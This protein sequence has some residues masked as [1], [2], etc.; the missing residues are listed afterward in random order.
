MSMFYM[1]HTLEILRAAYPYLN[2]RS[3]DT[4]ELFIKAGDFFECL[5]KRKNKSFV[6][7]FSFQ[8]EDNSEDSDRIDV[9]GLLKSVREVCYEEEVKLIDSLINLFNIME[10][11]DTYKNLFSMMS[12]MDELGGLSSMFGQ[13]GSANPEDMLGILSSMLPE[14]DKD[15]IDNISM[16]LKMMNTLNS[17]DPLSSDKSETSKDHDDHFDINLDNDETHISNANEYNDDNDENDENDDPNT[18]DHDDYGPYY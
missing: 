16:A 11:Y 5:Y 4:L 17:N 9:L 3:K 12:T 13:D 18:L 10:M 6:S 8:E 15:A 1:H 14:E 2:R 7:A